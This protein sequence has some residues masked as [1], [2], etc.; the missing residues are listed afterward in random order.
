MGNGSK[1][2]GR[3]RL[4]A[5]IGHGGMAEVYLALLEGD[6]GFNKLL[7]LKKIRPELAEDPEMM[8]MFLDEARLSAR[9]HHPN[10]VETHEVAQEDGHT[11]MAMEYLEGQSLHRILYRLRRE[12]GLPPALHLQILADVLAGL[13]HAHELADWD[14]TPL[15]VVHRDVTPQNVFV[16]Y[17]GGVKVVDFGIAKVKGASSETR[18]GVVKGKVA[19]MAPEQAR[20]EAVDRRTD[21]FAAGVMLWEAATGTRPFRGLSDVE[22]LHRLIQGEVPSAR[23]ANPA[24]PEAL[25]AIITRAI[26]PS[27]ADRYATAAELRAAIEGYLE[28]LPS[29]PPAR[30]LGRLVTQHFAE[31]R[32]RLQRRLEEELRENPA[33][34]TGV[35][36]FAAAEVIHDEP[37]SDPAVAGQSTRR[38]R[39]HPGTGASLPGVTRPSATRPLGRR[40]LVVA[41]AFVAVVLAAS[42]AIWVPWR[43]RPAAPPPPPPPIV[44]AATISPPAPAPLEARRVV[45]RVRV[46]PP[47]ARILLDGTALDGNPFAGVLAAD[48]AA[49]ELRI[50]APGHVARRQSLS[51]EQDSTLEIVLAAEPDAAPPHTVAPLPRPPSPPRGPGAASKGDRGKRSLDG[52]NPYE[53]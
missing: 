9:L 17:E 15:G 7:V 47:E 36:R 5:E 33:G 52:A 42:A 8:A 51:L 35:P 46:S 30:E 27:R 24:L 21:I 39:G 4:I 22:I 41:A 18:A 2:L 11:F 37:T 32:A 26:A 43:A 13:H 29:R 38:L 45:L 25:E 28:T 1:R 44:A 48:S 14:E 10:V 3:Y 20:G 6:L 50:E 19:Y 31:D 16:T 23:A 40:R 53:L 12:G 49:H 34:S